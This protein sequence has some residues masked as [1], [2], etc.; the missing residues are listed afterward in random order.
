MRL[1]LFGSIR[2]S[3]MLLVVMAVLPTLGIMLFT[4]RELHQTLIRSAEQSALRQVQAMALHH[5]RI[6][7]QARLLLTTIAEAGEIRQLNSLASQALLKDI[8]S[9]E[10]AYSALALTDIDGRIVVA[11]P[12]GSFADVG[13]RP[14]FQRAL[15]EMQFSMG[16]YHYRPD[17]QQV[18]L[19]FAQPVTDPTGRPLGVLLAAFDLKAFAHIFQDAHLPEGSIFTLTNAEGIRLI[20]FPHSTQ[21]TWV[22][23]QPQMIARMSGPLAEGT[24][25]ERGVDGIDRLYGFK[26]LTFSSAPFPHLMIRLGMPLDQALAEARLVVNRNLGFLLLAALLTMI[27]AWAVGEFTIMRRLNP[28]MRAVESLGSGNLGCRTGLSSDH[29][30]FGR[31]AAAF[32]RMAENLENQD[33]ERQKAEEEVCILNTELEERVTTRTAQLAAANAELQTALEDLRQAQNQLVLSE[34][35]SALGGLVAGVAHEINT[36]VGVALSATSTMADRNRT[37]HDLFI[38][39]E[40]KRSELTEYLE[41]TREGLEMTLLNLHRASEMIRSFKMV[42]ADQVSESRRS[43]KVREYI[44]EILLSLRPKLK[45]TTHRVEVE[46]DRELV[47]ESYPGALSQILTNLIFNSLIHAFDEGSSGTIRI[48]VVKEN[49]T[50]SLTY[51]DNGRGID[52]ALQNKIFEP[53]FTTARAKGSTGLGLH[54]VFNIVSSTLGGTITCCS[55]P[56]Q[57]TTFL[58]RI[59]L[60]RELP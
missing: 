43:F 57:G 6:V 34:K 44:E 50:L 2:A 31:L 24:F 10:A 23:D 41:S 20:R 16:S 3:L 13:R 19:D 33:W 51:A 14:F 60:K 46:C 35:L 54:I 32:D 56:G 21:Y 18:V 7:D 36:P 15:A 58:I 8:Q 22:A 1:L 30:E 27:A 38:R 47:I 9:R 17:E 40:M 45:K 48:K 39:G 53:F 4:G 37:L 12:S 49:G 59:P 5:E 28:L 52:P 42:A 11:V 55:E 26:R 29:T 25:Q